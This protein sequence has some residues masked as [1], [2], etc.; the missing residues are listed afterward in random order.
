MS[1]RAPLSFECSQQP[2]GDS[3]RFQGLLV[4]RNVGVLRRAGLGYGIPGF[5]LDGNDFLAVV[6]L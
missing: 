4:R 6:R 2:V 3:Q 1:T 5:E